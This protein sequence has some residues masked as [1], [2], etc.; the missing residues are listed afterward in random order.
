M[1]G[2]VHSDSEESKVAVHE[3][4]V[5]A[6]ADDAESGSDAG[7]EEAT[8]YEIEEVLD[9]KRGQF[10]DGRMGYFVKWKGYGPEDNSWVDEID[11]GNA[12]DL[13]EQYWRKHPNKQKK[14]LDKKS[15]KKSRKSVTSDQVSD[16]EEVTSSRKRG[17]KSASQKLELADDMDVDEIEKPPKK[18]RTS[19]QPPKSKVK[20]I[21]SSSP[22]S[23]E[24]VIGT[25]KQYMNL[26]NWE[27]LVKTVDTV[28]RQESSNKLVVYFT[29][30][31][32]DKVME[33]SVICKERF[34]Q[35]LLEFYESN[36]RWR[37]IEDPTSD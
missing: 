30:N 15:P 4:K 2:V 25:M 10:P 37:S 31:T 21:R 5:K 36:L 24:Q 26:K 23:E 34:P 28:E 17:R 3:S 35:K 7:S 32:G 9:A 6:A 22:E 33:N 19:A 1:P 14:L 11:A 27:G 29:L 8:E 16:V 12:K 20:K 18:A 13:V